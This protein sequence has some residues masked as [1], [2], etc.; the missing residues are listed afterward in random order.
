MLLN[1]RHGEHA[2]G[3]LAVGPGPRLRPLVA[4]VVAVER[5]DHRVPGQSAS[6]PAQHLF[7]G[8]TLLDAVEPD[9][10]ERRAVASHPRGWAPA[11]GCRS[12]RPRRPCS[13]RV[14]RGPA[15]RLHRAQR[16]SAT[17]SRVRSASSQTRYIS[18]SIVPPPSCS[19]AQLQRLAQRRLE[20]GVAQGA[21]QLEHHG[22]VLAHLHPQR[23]LRILQCVGHRGTRPARALAGPRDRPVCSPSRSTAHTARRSARARGDRRRASY[24]ARCTRARREPPGSRSDPARSARSPR[25]PRARAW[26][27]RRPLRAASRSCPAPS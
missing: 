11:P 27:P 24:P 4:A 8:V 9:R 13:G 25:A 16:S 17:S 19:P 26:T 22:G 14:A 1:E 23:R 2:R 3:T 18:F 12:R 5:F 6:H 10:D 7:E 21:A 15:A 20:L